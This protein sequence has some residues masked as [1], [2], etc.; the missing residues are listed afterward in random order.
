M[1]RSTRQCMVE[2][3]RRCGALITG[4]GLVDRKPDRLCCVVNKSI[5][6]LLT[7]D[8]AP[9]HSHHFLMWVNKAR[10]PSLDMTANMIKS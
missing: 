8:R 3:K 5:V 9:S 2:T 7:E 4:S 1:V 6:I 10:D